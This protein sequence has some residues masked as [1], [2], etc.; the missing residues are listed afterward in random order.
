MDPP[1]VPPG[2][3]GSHWL[4][5]SL[6]RILNSCAGREY[7]VGPGRTSLAGRTARQ[8]EGPTR[9]QVVCGRGEPSGTPANPGSTLG[10]SPALS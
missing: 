1:V 5:P 2:Q 9:A 7:R 10:H 3:L 4:F 8:A 6:A